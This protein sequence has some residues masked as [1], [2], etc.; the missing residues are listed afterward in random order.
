MLVRKSAALISRAGCGGDTWGCSLD[1]PSVYGMEMWLK[2]NIL[3]RKEK[4]VC[5]CAHLLLACCKNI[6]IENVG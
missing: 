4:S 6:F 1:C 3:A 5:I 2:S